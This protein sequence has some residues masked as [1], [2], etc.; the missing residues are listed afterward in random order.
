MKLFQAIYNQID[1]P[2]RGKSEPPAKNLANKQVYIKENIELKIFLI[3]K[4]F[5][6]YFSGFKNNVIV[7]SKV[8]SPASASSTQVCFK[9]LISPTFERF[10]ISSFEVMDKSFIRRS[11][12]ISKYS[13][14]PLTPRNVWAN[15]LNSCDGVYY[16]YSSD[17][18]FDTMF[19]EWDCDSLVLFDTTNA[20]ISKYL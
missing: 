9:C 18:H 2:F 13:K 3:D 17:L 4:L 11:F 10:I 5:S 16:E 7:C 12:V 20:I 15:A 1:I 19:N 8:V 6:I 14:T